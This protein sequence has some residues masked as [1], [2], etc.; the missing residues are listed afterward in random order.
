M[1]KV[2]MILAVGAALL[3]STPIAAVS[4][5][6]AERYY[7]VWCHDTDGNL[8]E[9]ESVD[10]HAVEQGGKRHAVALFTRNYPFNWDCWL[11]G[12]FTPST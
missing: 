5:P 7:E 12:P 1:R 2:A 10:A 11:E 8:V 6:R 4:T 9:S 3:A